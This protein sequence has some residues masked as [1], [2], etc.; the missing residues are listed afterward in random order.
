MTVCILCGLLAGVNAEAKKK[1]SMEFED[2]VLDEIELKVEAVPEEMGVIVRHFSAE[3]ADLGTGKSTK[4][5]HQKRRDGALMIQKVGPDMLAE[6]LASDLEESG[7]FKY[8][9]ISDEESPEDAL[10]IGG[11]ILKIEPGSKAARFW[12]GFGAGKSGIQ[13]AGTLTNTQGETLAEFKHMRHSGIGV[14]GG[15][16]VKFLSDDVR[17]VGSDVAKFLTVWAR[18]GDLSED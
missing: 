9:R 5:K 15:D 1:S 13:V 7:V 8:V 14:G 11:E 6:R 4:E 10:I 17:D 2:G 3:N 12:G 18:G 16:Y